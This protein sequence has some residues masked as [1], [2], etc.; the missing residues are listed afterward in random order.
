MR[1]RKIFLVAAIC[2]ASILLIT[3]AC[4]YFIPT[5]STPIDLTLD[6]LKTDNDGNELGT[7]P[8]TVRGT[9]TEYL[10][11]DDRISIE[12][13]PIEDLYDIKPWETDAFNSTDIG[14]PNEH[15]YYSLI[16]SASSTIVGEDTYH[17]II[18]FQEDL[19]KWEIFRQYRTGSAYERFGLESYREMDFE[20][21]ATVE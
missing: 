13:S 10:F 5:K 8:I 9:L 6:A 20:Y 19:S 14:Q 4:L 16:C 1:K 21:R 2:L 7:V 17:L 15:G 3:A 12:I 18:Y 11:R